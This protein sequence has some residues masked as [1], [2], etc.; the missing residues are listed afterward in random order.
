MT[1]GALAVSCLSCIE[2]TPSFRYVYVCPSRVCMVIHRV[3]HPHT[4]PSC[5][6][7]RAHPL[8]SYT[9]QTH[10]NVEHLAMMEA[11]LGPL[12]ARFMRETRKSKYF[13]HGQL[14]WDPTSPDGKYVREHCRKLKVNCLLALFVMM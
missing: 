3:L 7:N 14:D 9:S 10:D 4:V 6:L 11:I 5:N 1:C 2:D 13:W 12:P 8:S